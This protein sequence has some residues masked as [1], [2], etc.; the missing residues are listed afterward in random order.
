MK[1][2]QSDQRLYFQNSINVSLNNQKHVMIFY[3]NYYD[4]S[5]DLSKYLENEYIDYEFKLIYKYFEIYNNYIDNYIRNINQE[6]ISLEKSVQHILK[7]K[8]DSFMNNYSKNISD[9][10]TYDYIKIYRYNHSQCLNYQNMQLNDALT[11]D[12]K[13]SNLIKNL[14]PIFLIIAHLIK[15]NFYLQMKMEP[16]VLLYLISLIMK[17]LISYMQKII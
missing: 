11:K 1:E 15:L 17:L 8:Y 16:I 4:L 14:L 5:H 7:N 13:N 12:L 10:V 3:E 9:F 2:L 6:I